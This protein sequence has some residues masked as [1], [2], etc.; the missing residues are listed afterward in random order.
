MNP[1]YTFI[2]PQVLVNH[3]LSLLAEFVAYR[4]GCAEVL[5]HVSLTFSVKI[6]SHLI[7]LIMATHES[8]WDAIAML[9]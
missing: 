7:R 1:G 3:V 5:D 6:A 9:S 2:D 4:R 8:L